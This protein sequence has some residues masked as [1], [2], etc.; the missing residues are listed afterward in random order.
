MRG[1]EEFYEWDD[2]R[3]FSEADCFKPEP[4]T[5]S[6]NGR[7]EVNAGFRPYPAFRPYPETPAAAIRL[8]SL[9]SYLTLGLF[10]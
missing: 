3:S 10:Q 6:A 8:R 1:L 4:E 2:E 7:E 5:A 9:L